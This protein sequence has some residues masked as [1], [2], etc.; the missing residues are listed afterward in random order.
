M[1]DYYSP[2]VV[3][4]EIPLT[5][6]T[7]LERLVLTSVFS[8]EIIDAGLYLYSE[9]GPSTWLSLPASDLREALH[10]SA[11]YESQLRAMFE[12]ALD[13]ASGDS[14]QLDIDLSGSSY[15]YMLQDI[16]RRSKTLPYITVVTSFTCSKMRPDGFGGCATLITRDTIEGTST[17]AILEQLIAAHGLD[18][19]RH[20]SGAPVSEE[21]GGKVPGDG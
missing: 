1:A 6:I 2:T 16:V 18:E 7:P 19:S 5:D 3:Q 13:E 14:V 17:H 12:A 9:D 11:G 21:E 10:A 4:P 15:E 8:A 20:P